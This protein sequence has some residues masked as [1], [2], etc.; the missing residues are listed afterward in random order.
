MALSL[1]LGVLVMSASDVLL[2]SGRYPFADQVPR[3]ADAGVPIDE[4]EAV[5]E[6]KMQ[7]IVI[8]SSWAQAKGSRSI[9][10]RSIEADMPTDRSSSA[11]VGN[12][13]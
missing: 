3:F 13:H 1:H 4:G 12:L 8:A 7:W 2:F 6:G 10:V 11:I 9:T 5:M